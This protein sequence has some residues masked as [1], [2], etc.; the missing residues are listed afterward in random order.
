MTVSRLTVVAAENSF[1]LAAGYMGYI[2]GSL[3]AAV[4]PW[5]AAVLLIGFGIGS[6]QL[7]GYLMDFARKHHAHGDEAHR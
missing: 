7:S 1:L 6:V 4:G 3:E 5:H 2:L